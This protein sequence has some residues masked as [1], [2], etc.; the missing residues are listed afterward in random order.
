MICSDKTGTLTENRM[1]VTVVDAAG[2]RLNL[3]ENLRRRTPTMTAEECRIS[4]EWD[5]PLPIRLALAA[6]ALCNDAVLKPDPGPGCFHAIGDPTEG[7][8]LVAA[9]RSGMFPDRL[10]A[11]APRVAEVPFDSNRKRMTTIHRL[12]PGGTPLDALL[13][14]KGTGHVAFTKGAVDGLL[15]LSTRVW[16]AE[17]PEPLTDA[18]REQIRATNDGL[19]QA[20]M[21]VLGVAFRPLA[22]VLP[23]ADAGDIERDLTF[24]G[25]VGLMDPPREAVRPAVATCKAAGIRTVDD[26]RRPPAHR[27]RHRP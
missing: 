11:E 22:A 6:G 24:L 23:A 18:L 4:A 17:R 21:R 2:E 25:L 13:A 1:T 5:L 12:T 20:G 9:A 3:M 7:A 15:E 19:A 14:F 26:H 10:Q 8:L 16:V 27:G